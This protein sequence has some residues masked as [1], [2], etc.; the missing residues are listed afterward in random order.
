MRMPYPFL[1]QSSEELS[2]ICKTTQL[3]E[4]PGLS[5][6]APLKVHAHFQV[7]P[8]FSQGTLDAGPLNCA[9]SAS[10]KCGRDSV[11]KQQ[12]KSSEKVIPGAPK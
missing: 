11:E 6:P 8:T 7:A 2:I 10:S 3:A 12:Q 5:G 1:S 9:E 4:E